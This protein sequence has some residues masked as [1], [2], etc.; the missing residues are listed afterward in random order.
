MLPLSTIRQRVQRMGLIARLPAALPV[1]D[2]LHI[3]DALL[4]APLLIVEISYAS[5]PDFTILREFRAS[6][7]T[8]LLCGVADLPHEDPVAA[9][10]AAGA[11]YVVTNGFSTGALRVCQRR[12]ALYLPTIVDGTAIDILMRAGCPGVRLAVGEGAHATTEAAIQALLTTPLLVTVGPLDAAELA[13]YASDQV[14]VVLEQSLFPSADW[15]LPG[16]ITQARQL[17]AR[18]E[19]ARRP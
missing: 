6:F 8:H 9:A 5:D 2:L 18:W 19:A 4:A 16:V 17:R 13:D 15:S 11:H 14:A 10:L 3:G 1:A 7:G 12:G